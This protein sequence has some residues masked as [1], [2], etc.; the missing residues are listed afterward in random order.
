MGTRPLRQYY[1]PGA[2]VFVADDLGP[3]IE[4][5]VHH[6]RRFVDELARLDDDQW[7][8]R[9]R[10]TD[11]T[12]QDVLS[13]L[14]TADGFWMASLVGAASGTPTAYLSDFD[15]ASTPEAL[16]DAMRTMTPAE[17]LGQFRAATDSFIGTIR[18]LDDE[19]WSATGES[20]IGHVTARLALAHALWDS[21]LHERDILVPLGVAVPVER[22]ELLVCTWYTL[23]MGAV[24]GGLLHDAAP[25][26]PGLDAP[27]DVTLR[28]D[29]LPD[30]PLHLTVGEEVRL[31]RGGPDCIE[32][33]S[34][35]DLV[36]TYTGRRGTDTVA[37]LPDPLAAQLRRALQIL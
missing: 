2:K 11:W 6:R 17:V 35:V 3:V 23:T 7:D 19:A 30:D 25:V 9:T 26:G 10:C 20:P 29:D 8:T 28:F 12:A 18:G 24:Q 13:H 34:A 22:D 14:V 33:G 15:P 32:V 36:E 27:I 1:D 4:P 21:W 37:A 16:V 31:E 5:W